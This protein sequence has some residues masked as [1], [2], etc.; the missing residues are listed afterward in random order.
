M[1]RAVGKSEGRAARA[2]RIQYSLVGDGA[3]RNDYAIHWMRGEVVGEKG[4]AA[5]HFGGLGFVGGRHATHR[6]GDASVDQPQSVVR[7]GRRRR[8]GK[9]VVKQGLV[10]Q[11]AGMV[12]VN[13]RP[14]R[15]AP[16]KPGASPTTSRRAFAAPKAGTGALW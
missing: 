2:E 11:D 3:K 9:T 16:C 14:L 15:L 5:A 10:E 7:R 4:V 13:G 1:L 8:A 12:P 6:I